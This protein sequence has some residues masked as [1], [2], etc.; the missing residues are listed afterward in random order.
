MSGIRISLAKGRA[1]PAPERGDS[2]FKMGQVPI[3][4]RFFVRARIR[5]REK[6]ISKIA[7]RLENMVTD[8]RQRIENVIK[9]AERT[10]IHSVV[11]DARALREKLEDASCVKPEFE[12]IAEEVEVERKP[13]RPPKRVPLNILCIKAI[14]KDVFGKD[15]TTG[16]VE[17]KGAAQEFKRDE[18]NVYLRKCVDSGGRVS[19]SAA[20]V[21]ALTGGAKKSDVDIEV[22]EA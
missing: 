18:L 4:S 11:R 22:K 16:M 17:G 14:A 13:S 12:K 6:A 8:E 5:G 2:V 7:Q 15:Q 20:I 1:K 21:D 19:I 10:D 3:L 9:A